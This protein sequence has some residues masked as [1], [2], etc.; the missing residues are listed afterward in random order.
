MRSA[1]QRRHSISNLIRSGML[2]PRKWIS[3]EVCE[4]ITVPELLAVQPP[5]AEETARGSCVRIVDG[6]RLL[7]KRKERWRAA[8][9]WFLLCPNP[10]CRGAL[11]GQGREYLI[12][13]PDA[14]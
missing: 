14:D 8:R 10:R 6:V 11:L 12:R 1:A 9:F 2:R 5:T 4:Q 3:I 7:L 13:L